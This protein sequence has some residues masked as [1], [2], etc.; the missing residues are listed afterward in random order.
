MIKHVCLEC[1]KA[2]KCSNVRN[3]ETVE[4]CC[5]IELMPD[6]AGAVKKVSIKGSRVRKHTGLYIIFGK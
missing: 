5:D 3:G 2:G 1:V 6:T 4:S